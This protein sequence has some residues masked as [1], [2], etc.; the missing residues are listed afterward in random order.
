[1][2]GR[3]RRRAARSRPCGSCAETRQALVDQLRELGAFTE[4]LRFLE[5]GAR[6]GRLA[7]QREQAPLVIERV[8][9]ARTLVVGLHRF[10][11]GER[12]LETLL[13]RGGVL[14]LLG[15]HLERD[16]EA[17]AREDA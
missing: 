12:L 15:L 14:L 4:L 11:R 5:L 13:A 3:N 2:R 16:A 7:E 6:V 8:R 1:A 17:L 10:E 9:V